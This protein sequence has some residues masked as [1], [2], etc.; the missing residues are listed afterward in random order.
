MMLGLTV[1]IRDGPAWILIGHEAAHDKLPPFEAPEQGHVRLVA[2]MRSEFVSQKPNSTSPFS[3]RAVVA[4][5][6][7]CEWNEFG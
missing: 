1:G 4:L 3:R 5:C 7:W 2:G 6:N